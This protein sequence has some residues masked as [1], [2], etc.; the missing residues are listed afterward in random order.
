MKINEEIKKIFQER[1]NF[2]FIK[3]TIKNKSYTY[4]DFLNR[5]KEMVNFLRSKKIKEGDK[6]IIKL[7]NSYEYLCLVF[8]CFLGN[9]VACPLDTEIKKDKFKE[10]VNIL[11]PSIKITSL[12]QIKPTKK[13]YNTHIKDNKI[14]LIIFTSGTT[15]KPKGIAIS[16]K[17]YLNSSKSFS[18]LAEYSE[19]SVILH[20]LPMYY[21]A[22]LLNTFFAAF[23]AKSTI[24]IAKKISALNISNFWKIFDYEK[25][26][27]THVTPE[28]ANV[29]TRFKKN[30]DLNKK[31]FNLQ[32]ISTGSYLHPNIVDKFEKIYNKRLLS[33]YGLTELGG[34]LSLQC[35]EN[36]YV[37]GSV[38]YHSEEIKIKILN[39]LSKKQILIK[40][41]NS[42]SFFID[43][44]GKKF[45]PKLIN[46][47]F[48]TGD[49][50]DY[51]KK[52]LFIFGRRK[53]IIKKGAEIVSI[54]NI[55]NIF[56][57]S[58]LVDEA[59]GVSSF[60]KIKGSKIYLFVKFKNSN[61]LNN[62]LEKLKKNVSKYLKKIEL[63]D[64]I[65]PVPT[66]PKTYNGKI[67]KELLREIYL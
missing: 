42:M 45:K 58:K 64:K 55:E 14:F 67:K 62:K 36:T 30:L 41:P 27:S 19:N 23:V 24:V 54:P 61:N 51:K 40:S 49:I 35:W 56:L 48:N 59:S 28:I 52:E 31:I 46:G 39:K 9:F 44:R 53:D 2:I 25:I 8:A 18:Q 66:L 11:K 60:D 43:D 47:Y 32:I 15:G 13:Q 17:A 6:I 65:I 21:N 29:L 20:F 3:D 34:P 5:S 1:K 50:G 38:G 37:K 26:N 33:C 63:P 10:I 22:G 12:K 7:E 57:K 4:Q 16:N